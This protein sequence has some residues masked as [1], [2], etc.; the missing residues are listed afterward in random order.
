MAEDI[1]GTLKKKSLDGIFNEVSHT[2]TLGISNNEEL[3]LFYLKVRG[4]KFYTDD[5]QTALYR[6]IGKYVFSRATLE[7]FHIRDDDDSVISQALKVMRENGTADMKGTGNE[8][9]EMLIYT[10]LEEKLDAPKILSR[11]ELST[12]ALSFNSEC[13]SIHLLTLGDANGQATYEMV[14][15]ASNIVGDIQ[16]AIDNAFDAILRIENH[17]SKEIKMVEK[18]ALSRFYKP[19]E[20][21]FIKKLIVPQQGCSG[22]YEIAYGI[23]L[24]YTLGIDPTGYTNDQ[25]ATMVEKRLDL[26][27]KSHASYIAQKIRDCNLD[28][29][30]FYFYILPFDN[31][32]LN[33]K[34]VM[35]NIMKGD[36]TL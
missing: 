3:R 17:S 31:A 5:L 36:V 30:S 34:E 2:E 7:D 22:D 32:E 25:Y 28:G 16:D 11:V 27:I 18:S 14:F 21:E 10:L 35:E 23:F 4:K 15:G 24:G 33:K 6:N 1:S 20:I 8:L 12:D 29:H 9:G 26:D 19:S 13:E